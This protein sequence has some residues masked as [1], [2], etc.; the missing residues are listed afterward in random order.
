M[1]IQNNILKEYLKNVYF[2]SGT[3]CG[4]KSTTAGVLHEKYGVPV[5]RIDEHFDEHR[6]MSDPVYQPS[7]N[8]SFKDADEFFGRTVDE[9]EDWLI[10]NSREQLDFIV[11][12]L[13]RLS[14]DS[15]II[16]DCLITPEQA[17][18]LTVPERVAFLIREPVNLADQYADRPDHQGFRNWLESASDVSKAKAV[19]NETLCRIN[20]RATEDIIGSGYFFLER[21]GDKTPEEV[22]ELVAQ[23]FAW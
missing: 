1:I 11:L 22:A 13:I 8:R 15:R 4:G 20:R 12:D 19:C 5:Y 2:I 14:H 7:M 9:Y 6:L 23:H 18:Q 10:K 3:A 16:C 21:R 17:A